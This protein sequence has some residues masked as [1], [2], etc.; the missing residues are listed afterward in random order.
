MHV[1]A[2]R[3]SAEEVDNSVVYK[4]QVQRFTSKKE[5]DNLFKDW[6]ENAIGWNVKENYRI[7][8]FKK[9]FKSKEEWIEWANKFPTT[10]IEHKY[11]AGEHK[12]VVLG[13]KGK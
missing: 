1:S 12:I 11:R 10:V 3:E 5:V 4:V 8:I 6:S 2:W 7:V 13:K 9:N